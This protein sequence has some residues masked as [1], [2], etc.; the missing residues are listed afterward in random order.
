MV[1][2]RYQIPFFYFPKSFEKYT[3]KTI[4]AWV[5]AQAHITNGSINFL[6]GRHKSQHMILVF[7]YHQVHCLLNNLILHYHSFLIKISIIL[8]YMICNLILMYHQIIINQHTWY[9]TPRCINSSWN[10]KKVSIMSPNSI[11]WV[12]S[13]SLKNP[14]GFLDLY[15][16]THSF[17]CKLD[18]LE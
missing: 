4:Q 6:F 18:K 9:F 5:V 1:N 16:F 17:A 14:L 12:P 2:L 13:F 7:C 15:H 10:V 3:S 11:H 8:Y